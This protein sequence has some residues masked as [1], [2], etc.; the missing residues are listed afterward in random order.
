MED[1]KNYQRKQ[2]VK[3]KKQ[4][5]SLGLDVN[6]EW[7]LINYVASAYEQ[8]FED[9]IKKQKEIFLKSSGAVSVIC[10]FLFL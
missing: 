6:Q 5:Y 4:I 2:I 10:L 9:G 3:L 1:F 8:G 7:Q